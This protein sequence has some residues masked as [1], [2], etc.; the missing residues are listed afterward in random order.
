MNP[1]ANREAMQNEPMQNQHAQEVVRQAEEELRQL[2][3]QRIDVM[4]RIGTIK[5]TIAGLANL[6][7]DDILSDESLE[8]LDRKSSGRQPG[9][10][11]ACRA[12]LMEANRALSARDVCDRLQE[13][14]ALLLSR[15]KDPLASVTTVLNRLVSYGEAVAVV[16][17]NGRRAWRWVADS[18]SLPCPT[19]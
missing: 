16:L 18:D 9:F 5:Q 7:G 17:E 10:T 6:F 1:V 2:L 11:R 14:S 4:R 8:L 15:H 12:I 3:R 13:K 19:L